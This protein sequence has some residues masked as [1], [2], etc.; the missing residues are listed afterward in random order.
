MRAAPSVVALLAALIVWPLAAAADNNAVGSWSTAADLLTGRAGHTATLLDDGRVLVTG[1]V[2]DQ[3]RGLTSC[4]IYD[5][6]TNTWSRAAGMSTSRVDHAAIRLGN[7]DV[8]V[9]GGTSPGQYTVTLDSAEVYHPA[10]DRW[11]SVLPMSIG[12]VGSAVTLL[13]NGLVL[14]AG[15]FDSARVP[16]DQVPPSSV[17][18]FSP[19]S[20]SWYVVPRSPPSAR[21]QT[22]TLLPDGRVLVAGGLVAGAAQATVDIYDSTANSWQGQFGMSRGR[23]GQTATLLA[24]GRVLYLGGLADTPLEPTLPLRSG[25]IYD[26]GSNRASLITEMA[27]PRFGHTA[28]L[29]PDGM[30]LVVGSAYASTAAAVLYDPKTN[31]WLLAGALTQRYNHTATSLRDGRVLIAGGHGVGS[32]PSAQLFDPRGPGPFAGIAAAAPGLAAVL[33][34]IGSLALVR[35]RLT[36]GRAREGGLGSPEVGEQDDWISS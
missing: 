13:P 6:K 1:G 23:W 8:L 7:G 30:V 27:V 28:T 21:A 12:R 31:R 16:V 18:L 22:A 36:Q 11:T 24:N 29:L 33:A 20:G 26:P 32:L 19:R 4:E 10:S 15:G 34:L 5:P 17:E 25:E 2:D 14:V 9:L 3:G 35:Y